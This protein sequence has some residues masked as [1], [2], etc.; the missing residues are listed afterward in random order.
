MYKIWKTL[1]LLKTF[2]TVEKT[3]LAKSARLGGI[4]I[5]NYYVTSGF[6]KSLRDLIQVHRIENLVPRI[7]KLSTGLEAEKIRSLESEKSGPYWAPNIFLKKAC[8][9]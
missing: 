7:K 5:V 1:G 8:I 2:E 9:M 4:Q 6:L 3:W